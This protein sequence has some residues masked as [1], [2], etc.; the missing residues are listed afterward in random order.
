MPGTL[1]GRHPDAVALM[2][3]LK[4]QERYDPVLDGLVRVQVRQDLLRQDREFGRPLMEKLTTGKIAELISP[5]YRT[6]TTTAP[7]SGGWK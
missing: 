1:R 3:Y 2:R 6:L 4:D 7:S 5:D